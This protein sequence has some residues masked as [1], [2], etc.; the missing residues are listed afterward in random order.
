[1]LLTIGS[2]DGPLD[3]LKEIFWLLVAVLI[4]VGYAGVGG[5]VALLM[6]GVF[7]AAALIFWALYLLVGGI[8]SLFEMEDMVE[9]VAM[10]AR[11]STMQGVMFIRWWKNN[12]LFFLPNGGPYDGYVDVFD[13]GDPA[14]FALLP[15][16]VMYGEA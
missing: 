16:I 6:L 15:E 8:L 2:E 12:V 7:G 13:D 5:A 11:S 3:F 14:E 10:L 1:M 4:G 9:P